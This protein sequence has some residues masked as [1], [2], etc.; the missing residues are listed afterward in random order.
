MV[1]PSGLRHE[2]GVDQLF[3]STTDRRGVIQ[4]ANSVFVEVSRY[5]WDRLVG[6]PHNIIRHPDMPA[7]AFKVV[8]DGLLAGRTT[9][10]YVDN[11]AADGSTYTVFATIT[12][13]GDGFLS[14]RS[15]PCRT[16]LLAAAQSLY[17]Q[18]R[19]GE[20]HERA[21]GVAAHVVAEHGAERLAGLLAEAGFASYDDFIEAALTAEVSARREQGA[22]IPH[23]PDAAGPIATVLDAVHVIDGELD[24]YLR[25]IGKLAEAAAALADAATKAAADTA[26]RQEAAAEITK[27]AA[28]CTSFAP[29]LMPVQLWVSMG[30]QVDELIDSVQQ[31]LTELRQ[32]C[33]LTRVRFALAELHTSALGQFAVEILDGAQAMDSSAAMPTLCAA[34]AEGMTDTGVQMLRNAELAG[35]AANQIDETA[36]IMQL[37]L[38]LLNAWRNSVRTDDPIIAQLLPLIDEQ[39]ARSANRIASLRE[40]VRTCQQI[41]HPL[42]M[43]TI[44]SQITRIREAIHR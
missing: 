12:P 29:A 27:V 33:G 41:A 2:I 22:G 10:A 13:L 4:Q 16:D 32:S 38:D 24:A 3:F 26:A 37:P 6:A 40:L 39:M 7:G 30:S 42:P 11:L 43:D 21:H 36:G 35:S 18:V 25:A 44:N 28:G 9:C 20:L 17:Q 5:P 31:T 8:W 14:V 15:R 23:R 19:P 34:L 1:V